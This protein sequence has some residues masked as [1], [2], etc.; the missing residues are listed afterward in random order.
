MKAFIMA[1]DMGGWIIICKRFN[2]PRN[3]EDCD[4]EQLKLIQANSKAMNMIYCA[5]NEKDFKNI[6]TCSMAKEIWEMSYLDM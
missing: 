2:V 1:H 4:E 5:M 3:Y 6:S